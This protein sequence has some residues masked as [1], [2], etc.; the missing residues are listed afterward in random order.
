M[1]KSVLVIDDDPDILDALRFLFEDAGF[2]VETMTKNGEAVI[3]K[4]KNTPPDV[5]ILDVLLSGHDGRHLCKQLKSQIDTK[6][7][8]IIMISAHPDAQKTSLDAGAN[9]FLA[10]PFDIFELLSQVEKFTTA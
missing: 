4:V 5:I 7:I 1:I 2:N 10:K 6:D 8:P 3:K 9:S